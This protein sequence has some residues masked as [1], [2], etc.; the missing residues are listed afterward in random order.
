[1][2][3]LSQKERRD[4][5]CGEETQETSLKELDFQ[6]RR[7]GSSLLWEEAAFLWFVLSCYSLWRRVPTGNETLKS[8]VVLSHSR[9]I[10][11]MCQQKQ[12]D[13]T[14][15][16][17]LRRNCKQNW[18]SL[19]QTLIILCPKNHQT[20]RHLLKKAISL[21]YQWND[22]LVLILETKQ[23]D[24]LQHWVT[25]EETWFLVSHACIDS[26]C[27]FRVTK[28]TRNQETKESP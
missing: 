14:Q 5:S 23:H 16:G 4:K 2:I 27:W 9:G 17:R 10:K 8:S 7:K 12:G 26:C 15:R 3:V 22:I 28:N 11:N 24:W 18:K 19:R 21:F 1:M 6:R 13:S 25:D 20:K